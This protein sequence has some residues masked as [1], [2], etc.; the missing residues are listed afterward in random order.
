MAEVVV[1][2]AGI[3]G[4]SAAYH[5]HA[6]GHR[7]TVLDRDPNGDR[8][9]SG[10]AGGIGI[11]EIVPASVPGLAWR[12]PGWLLDPLGPLSVRW[13]HFPNLLPW[14][15]RFVRS[16]NPAEVER[17]TNALA[18]L[19][20]R[21]F[22]DFVPLL[23]TLGLSADLHR[24]GA[25]TVY[26]TTAGFLRDLP[27]WELKRRHGILAEEIPARRRASASRRWVHSCS[28]R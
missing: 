4:L 15:W 11:S 9:S 14:L 8:A 24:V 17:I 28:M 2:G 13:R 19:A 12:V 23:A 6:D 21:C 27:E 7:V 10:N 1:I 5:L 22:D 18:A 20:S 16:G 3:V 26:E 25:L